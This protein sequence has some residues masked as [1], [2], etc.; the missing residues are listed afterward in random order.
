MSDDVCCAFI[1]TA[2]LDVVA[3]ICIDFASVRA[4]SSTN[5][6]VARI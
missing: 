4:Y 1:L 5:L 6:S 3:G 2:C